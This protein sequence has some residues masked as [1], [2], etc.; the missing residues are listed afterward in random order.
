MIGMQSTGPRVLALHIAAGTVYGAVVSCPDTLEP[1]L[2][3]RLQ[4]AEGLESHEQLADFAARFRQELRQIAPVAVGV[5]NTRLYS[6]WNYAKAFA[7]ISVEAAI[8][9]TVAETS[10][11]AT[12]I[13]YRLVKQ[14]S[15]A[16]KMEIP[17]PKLVE[18]A[19]Q[20]WGDVVT[21]YRGDRLPAVVAAMMLAKEFC[22]E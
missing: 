12:P 4:L 5:V 13:A 19:T 2:V 10:T 22:P 3:E 1:D 8:M 9:L 6:N 17:L 15:M 7:R 11:A 21:R 14:E 18:V 20:R 16:K